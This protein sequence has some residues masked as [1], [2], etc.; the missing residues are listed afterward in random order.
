MIQDKFRK[1]KAELK[2][3]Y[4]GSSMYNA[5]DCMMVTVVAGLNFCMHGPPGCAK[6]D[7]AE[8]FLRRLMNAN[9]FIN[10]GSMWMS[11]EDLLGAIK[12]SKLEQDIYERNEE[13][14]LPW[15]H[16]AFLDEVGEMPHNLT[17]P[18]YSLMVNRKWNNGG[19]ILDSNLRFLLAATNVNAEDTEDCDAWWDRFHLRVNIDQVK[20]P[21]MLKKIRKMN[22][23]R[24]L[25]AAKN[26]TTITLEDID[27]AREE[28]LAV[29]IPDV[30]EDTLQIIIKDMTDA[31]IYQTTRR[32]TE[33]DRIIQASAWLRG[34]SEA[35]EA[36]L[37]LLSFA[38]WKAKEDLPKVTTIIGQ[39]SDDPE[40]HAHD[41]ITHA[42]ELWSSSQGATP[43]EKK[44][45]KRQMQG[46]LDKLDEMQRN[47]SASG[48][49]I[50]EITNAF[51]QVT[52]LIR[53]VK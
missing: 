42:S 21:E 17:R 53:G 38:F 8:N 20:D 33:I 15:A 51:H 45:I 24:R 5:I 50:G 18:L 4:L 13:G 36:D 16:G 40:N 9:V 28:S 43:Q 25:K 46:I 44:E 1:I 41:L 32:L 23:E 26:V 35:S 29:T 3:Q 30:I 14:R 52:S 2:E 10:H 27:Q 7:L 12:M 31:A 37:R 47:A 6:S 39:Y 49:S 48:S 34:H 11:I 19:K 22:R